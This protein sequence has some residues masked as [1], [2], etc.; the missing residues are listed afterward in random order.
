MF[1][2]EV[3]KAH[4]TSPWKQGRFQTETTLCAQ[5]CLRRVDRSRS[6][7]LRSLF[8]RCTVML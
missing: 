7:F 3:D 8:R 1:R 6:G 4:W 5:P 2:R